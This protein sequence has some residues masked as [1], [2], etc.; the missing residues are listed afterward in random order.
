MCCEVRLHI[1]AEGYESIFNLL[2]YLLN[3][4]EE[5]TIRWWNAILRSMAICFLSLAAFLV[6]GVGRQ[7]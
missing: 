6:F 2:F 3:M 5:T 7:T 1:F 4:R